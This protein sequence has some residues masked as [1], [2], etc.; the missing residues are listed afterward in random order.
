MSMVSQSRILSRLLL[1]ESSACN[2]NLDD[3]PEKKSMVSPPEMSVF[4]YS[5]KPRE[6]EVVA[7]NHDSNSDDEVPKLNPS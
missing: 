5:Q 3:S 7:V 1:A 2:N 6:E 4:G